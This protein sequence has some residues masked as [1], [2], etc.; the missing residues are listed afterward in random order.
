MTSFIFAISLIITTVELVTSLILASIS[1]IS[2]KT[3]ASIIHK[4]SS[5]SAFAI[6]L[7]AIISAIS[8]ITLAFCLITNSVIA[9]IIHTKR[10]LTIGSLISFKTATI[11]IQTKTSVITIIRTFFFPTIIPF[12]NK[13]INFLVFYKKT[14]KI[15]RT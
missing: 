10:W 2:F 15:L 13:F 6:G 14:L 4:W 8:L 3:I 9:T 7:W 12:L 5:V 11:S 1:S